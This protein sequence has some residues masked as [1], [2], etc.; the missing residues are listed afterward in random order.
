MFCQILGKA[1]ITQFADIYEH[2]VLIPWDDLKIKFN[3]P[4]SQKKTYNLIL[5]AT[6]DLPS[7]CHVDSIRHLKCKWPDG[8]VLDKLKAKNIYKVIDHN[9]DIIFHLNKIWY[10]SFDCKAWTKLLEFIWKSPVE[11]KIQCFK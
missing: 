3:I 2:D 6:K 11:P 8:T 4:Q 7:I 9:E 5:Q 1:G 10:C